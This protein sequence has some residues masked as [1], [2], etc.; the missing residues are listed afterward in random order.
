MDLEKLQ[1][2]AAIY[3]DDGYN[4]TQ[5]VFKAFKDQCEELKDIDEAFLAGFGAGFA[6]RGKVCGAVSAATA[7]VSLFKISKENPK[8]RKELYVLL[9]EFYKGFE[10][11]YGSLGCYEITGADFTTPE[12]YA[13]YLN[14]KHEKVCKALVKNVVKEVYKIIKA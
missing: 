3:F 5:S 9:R 12:G 8:N 14:E 13:L 7:I 4:C 1:D 2:R 11:T 6:G 10:D